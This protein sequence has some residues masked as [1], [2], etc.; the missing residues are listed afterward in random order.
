MLDV[1]STLFNL[2]AQQ[3]V[4]FAEE[5]IFHVEPTCVT[6]HQMS[7]NNVASEIGFNLQQFQ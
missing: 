6:V 7:T 2:K 1:R 3:T 5:N 4:M